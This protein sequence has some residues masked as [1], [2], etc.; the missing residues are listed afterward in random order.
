[1]E[2]STTNPPISPVVAEKPSSASRA[3]DASMHGL[4]LVVLRNQFYRD[5][6]HKMM[7]VAWGLF[8]IIVALVGYIFVQKEAQPKPTFFATEN[9]GRLVEITPLNQTNFLSDNAVVAWGV[10]AATASYT[11]NFANY[12]E[13]LQ[14]LRE[15]Y[16]QKGFNDMLNALKNSTNLA[17]VKK[18]KFVV[19]AILD[20]EPK[21]LKKGVSSKGIYIWQVQVP[22]RI[23]FQNNKQVIDQKSLITMLITRISTLETPK[24]IGVNQFIEETRFE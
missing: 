1:M 5:N 10:E 4:E 16:T 8:V 18:K 20:G 7:I 24:G 14:N 6:Y 9:T 19:S 2:D 11:F 17:A 12:R 21:V 23:T 22:I 3:K 13:A 15:Y